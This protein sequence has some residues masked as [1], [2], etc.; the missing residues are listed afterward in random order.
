[1]WHSLI[2]TEAILV[3]MLGTHFTTGWIS[4]PSLLVLKAEIESATLGFYQL[5][6]LGSKT[7]QS[8]YNQ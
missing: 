3:H 6:Y 8:T 1:M 7:A 5:G 2:P 4:D